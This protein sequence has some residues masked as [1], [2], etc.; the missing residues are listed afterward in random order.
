MPTIVKHNTS[1][2]HNSSRITKGI[3][4]NDKMSKRAEATTVANSFQ[5]DGVLLIKCYNYLILTIYKTIFKEQIHKKNKRFNAI[6]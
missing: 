6:I 1:I 2:R 3:A 4:T 5:K